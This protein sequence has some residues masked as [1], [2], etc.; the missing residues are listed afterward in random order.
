MGQNGL[1]YVTE[2]EL[3]MSEYLEKSHYQR[4]QDQPVSL[5]ILQ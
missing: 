5:C 1:N 3:S 4:V 2:I